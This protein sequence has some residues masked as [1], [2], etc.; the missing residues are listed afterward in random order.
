MD[1]SSTFDEFIH[2]NPHVGF[3]SDLN[4]AIEKMGL[5][6]VYEGKI[7]QEVI[8]SVAVSVEKKMNEEKEPLKFQRVLFHTM[9]EL[10]Q[11]ISKYSD[12]EIKGKGIII[13]GKASEKYYVSSG[14]VINNEKIPVLTSLIET[15]NAMNPDEL[16][17]LYDA[18]ISNGKFS[19]QGGAG[20]GLIDIVRKSK[21]KLQYNFE[22]LS[23][24]KSFFLITATVLKEK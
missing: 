11:N 12:D 17:A 8:K 6:M 1:I 4:K 21:Q 13:V 18:E 23:D 10:L 20:L 19:K 22:K 3:I 16:R 7:D 14:N 5:T 2:K 24:L 9:I 15:I